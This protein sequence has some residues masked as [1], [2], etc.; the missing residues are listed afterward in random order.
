[1]E[2]WHRRVLDYERS[3]RLGYRLCPIGLDGVQRSRDLG[4]DLGVRA[5]GLDQDLPQLDVIRRQQDRRVRDF[6]VLHELPKQLANKLKVGE[7]GWGGERG[8]GRRQ[9]PGLR[10]SLSADY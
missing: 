1:M 2:S 3:L 7:R 4:R 6:V 9:E 5:Q 8:V 10:P